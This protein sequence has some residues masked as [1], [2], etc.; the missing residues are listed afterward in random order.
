MGSFIPINLP[1]TSGFSY[2]E[3]SISDHKRPLLLEADSARALVA[4]ALKQVR[5]DDTGGYLEVHKAL[6]EYLPLLAAIIHYKS[7]GSL[8]FADNQ[9]LF[10]WKLPSKSRKRDLVDKAKHCTIEFERGMVIL[11]YILVY[12]GLAQE[13]LDSIA[14]AAG[15]DDTDKAIKYRQATAYLLKAQ[16]ITNYLSR[17]PVNFNDIPWDIHPTT[18]NM[19][20]NM[21]AG[22][23][24]VVV[25]RK[26]VEAEMDDYYRIPK[27]SASMVLMTRVAI[28]SADKFTTAHQLMDKK[29]APD[30]LVHWLK[31]MR[32]Y[33][34]ACSMRFMAMQ[35][36]AKGKLGNALGY[37][38]QA[39]DSLDTNKMK[40]MLSGSRA[41]AQAKSQL[42]EN[43]IK[44]QK[45]YKKENDSVAFQP[46]PKFSD[47]DEPW[48]SGRE[49]VVSNEVWE[50]KPVQDSEHEGPALIGSNEY[51]GKGN[52]F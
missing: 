19:F 34:V 35:Q 43:C 14:A 30:S 3:T 41:V 40:T 26:D 49:V 2:A 52:Y 47:I 27:S 22:L 12:V 5:N 6:E 20:G 38:N 48:P 11:S 37:I 28:Y 13:R 29:D 46:I 32:L 33:A 36:A 9:P 17:N 44:L 4:N 50:L 7:E 45:V 42:K 31:D 15:G 51:A 10:A 21:I 39:V 16:S 24:H 8:E 23:L 1:T 25:L 18:V